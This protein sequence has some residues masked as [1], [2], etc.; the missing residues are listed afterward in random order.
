MIHVAILNQ[1]ILHEIFS[2]SGRGKSSHGGSPIVSH[3]V[4]VKEKGIYSLV[5]FI[6]ELN[7]G[8][9]LFR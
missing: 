7:L 6:G 8:Y 5:D 1:G 3:M 4:L 2:S 9:E